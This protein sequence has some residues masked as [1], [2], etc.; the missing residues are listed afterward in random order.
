MYNN[1]YKVH[2]YFIL[3]VFCQYVS[4]FHGLPSH[5]ADDFLCYAE[6]FLFHTVPLIYFLFRCLCFQSH[7]QKVIAKTN[8]I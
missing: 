2:T 5:F 7:I 8:G 4:S 6:I 3:Y 1:I